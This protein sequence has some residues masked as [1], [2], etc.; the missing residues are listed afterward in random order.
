MSSTTQAEGKIEIS[1]ALV[2]TAS[3]NFPINFIYIWTAGPHEALIRVAF[4][5][6]SG[7]RVEEFKKRLRDNL[8]NMHRGKTPDFKDV[9]LAFEAGDIVSEIM[10]FGSP[11]P[12]EIAVVG[13]NL[14]EDR[15]YANRI[16]EQLGFI[17]SLRDVQFAEALDYPTIP[18]TVDREV[19]GYSNETI[20]DVARSLVAATSSSRY[21]VPNFWRDPNSGI[22]YQVQVE[23]P[24]SMMRT[25]NDIPNV[26]LRKMG[27]D[28][29]LLVRDVAKIGKGTM[30][31]QYHRYNM[32][33]LV[34]LTADIEGEDLGRVAGH[35]SKALRDVGEPPR[36]VTVDVR[37]QTQPMAD[38]FR[39]LFKGL[40]VTV[41][42]VFLLLMAYFQSASLAFIAVTSV[43]AAISGVVLALYI[44]NTTFESAVVHGHHHVGR[45]RHGQRDSAGNLRGAPSH[46]RRFRCFC[47]RRRGGEPI[48]ANSDDELCH[49]LGNGADGFG[50]G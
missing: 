4:K 46:G 49:G 37:G 33:R 38:M 50:P 22:G 31:G 28:G 8:P 21:V 3:N 23:I 18:V 43:P 44:T 2:G 14:E 17:K 24:L 30:P 5:E 10:S 19:A 6:N 40:G 47:R 39:N 48:A 9:K 1:I 20:A 41:L 25:H 7:L 15:A 32:R 27:K 34:S 11:T 13:P 12:I 16:K 45:R 35:L 42:A 29:Q 26:P 36:G